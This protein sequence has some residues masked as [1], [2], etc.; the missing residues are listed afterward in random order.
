MITENNYQIFIEIHEAHELPCAYKLKLKVML[1]SENPLVMKKLELYNFT[2]IASTAHPQLRCSNIL[3][4]DRRW[5]KNNHLHLP[6]QTRFARRAPVKFRLV[7]RWQSRYF[8][9]ACIPRGASARV[10]CSARGHIIIRPRGVRYGVS[11]VPLWREHDGW[12]AAP[13]AR[14]PRGHFQGGI[15]M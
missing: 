8:R 2:V 7:S 13:V 6:P 10:V 9:P 11:S 1:P 14:F 4:R 12:E 15:F 5:R 3:G